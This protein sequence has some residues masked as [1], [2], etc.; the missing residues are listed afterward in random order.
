MTRDYETMVIFRSLGTEA[1]VA[2]AVSQIEEPIKKF[3]G[4]IANSTSWG[5]RRFTYRIGRQQEGYYQLIQF[6]L[7][8]GQLAEVKRA[9][10][11]NEG[12][13]RFMILT[14]DEKAEAEAAA[15]AQARTA[16]AATT[17]A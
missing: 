13:L 2:Q 6:H 16:V 3:G 10:Q 1:D 15:A 17:A 14:R 9:F 5:R 12:I 7:E 4:R 8:S 11:L